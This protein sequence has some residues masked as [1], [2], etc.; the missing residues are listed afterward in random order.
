MSLDEKK[1]GHAGVR[2]KV[3]LHLWRLFSA[4]FAFYKMISCLVLFGSYDHLRLCLRVSFPAF[5]LS[6]FSE[7]NI[8]KEILYLHLDYPKWS[9][10][11][12]NKASKG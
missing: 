3:V 7:F 6:P 4:L 11:T 1:L 12:G 10:W 5:I 9:Y 2:R 8:A